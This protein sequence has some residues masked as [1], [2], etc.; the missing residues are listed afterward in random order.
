METLILLAEHER[1]EKKR[2]ILRKVEMS[3]AQDILG[4]CK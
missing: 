3:D 4:V 1:F 2:S